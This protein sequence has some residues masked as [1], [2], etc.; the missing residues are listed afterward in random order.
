MFVSSDVQPEQTGEHKL[1]KVVTVKYVT[2]LLLTNY[3]A[4]QFII[5]TIPLWLTLH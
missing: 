4:K 2:C 3:H 5:A 1:Y